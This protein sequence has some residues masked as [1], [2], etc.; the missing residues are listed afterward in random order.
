[1]GLKS[2]AVEGNLRSSMAKLILAQESQLVAP[3]NGCEEKFIK[4]NL[5]AVSKVL[6]G[7]YLGHHS[8]L[9]RTVSMHPMP[10][11]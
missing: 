2:N 5:S 1:M 3:L 7:S 9:S 4:H 6:S 11:S 10:E 8:S